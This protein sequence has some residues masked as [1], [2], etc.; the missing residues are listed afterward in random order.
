MAVKTAIIKGSPYLSAVGVNAGEPLGNTSKLSYAVTMEEKELPD[1]QNPGGGLDDAFD[2][3][4]S[5]SVSLACRHVS[6]KTLELALGGTATAVAA[7]A[8]TNE[9]HTVVSLGTLIALDH[10]SDMSIP[11]VVE[12]NV[13]ATLYVEGTDFV[14]KRMGIIPLS[15]G[16][17]PVA[18]VLKIDYTKLKHQ[19][20]Q[21]LVNM[22]QE[23]RLM[24]DGINERNNAP[25]AAI[26]HRVK[27]GP[28]KNIEFIGDDFISFDIEGKL[29]AYDAITGAGLSPYMELLV[30][31][32]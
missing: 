3:L 12:N 13:G 16:S 9:L 18:A 4:K 7:G 21:A 20:I 22:I 11:I 14:R 26:M 10:M 8:V 29:L 32:L 2:R 27:F 23:N 5:A 17:I 15:T 31:S 24:F 1:Y 19:R 30:G 25:W 28:A 6:I